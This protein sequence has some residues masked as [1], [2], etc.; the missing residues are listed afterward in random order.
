MPG[1]SQVISYGETANWAT[2]H[3][4]IKSAQT[5]S[6][7][8]RQHSKRQRNTQGLS[9]WHSITSASFFWQKQVTRP[10]WEQGN[11]CYSWWEGLQS[12][13]TKSV[14][15]GRN[16]ELKSVLQSVF[17]LFSSLSSAQLSLFLPI[18]TFREGSCLLLC[19]L[20]YQAV[21]P[22]PRWLH[23]ITITLPFSWNW[24]L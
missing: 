2:D 4:V 7:G 20:P 11:R 13:I 10:A 24:S 3:L 18:Q 17:Y 8:A 5:Y 16:K 14:A 15:L 19:L 1:N 12:P 6:H 9:Y 21:S 22:H 23:L